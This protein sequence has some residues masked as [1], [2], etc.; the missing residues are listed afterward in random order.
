[1]V[2]SAPGAFDAYLD[3]LVQ[4]KVKKLQSSGKL[5]L[6]PAN[7]PP[8]LTGG[9]RTMY[10]HNL[11][12][13]RLV[14]QALIELDTSQ[15]E[16]DVIKRALVQARDLLLTRMDDVSIANE[17]DWDTVNRHRGKAKLGKTVDEDRMIRKVGEEVRQEKRK[18]L[19]R[20]PSTP[21]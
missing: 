2:S 5:A 1:M 20:G 7:V 19:K 15:P 11:S 18:F 21:F 8:E 13:E 17:Y 3:S 4:E 16:I 12:V 10:E 14:Y 9:L 6:E